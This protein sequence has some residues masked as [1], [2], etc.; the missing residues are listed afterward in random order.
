MNELTKQ[1]DLY[2]Y[3]EVIRQL[4]ANPVLDLGMT[5]KRAG[6]VSRQIADSAISPDTALVGVDFASTPTLQ[7]YTV[8]YDRILTMEKLLSDTEEFP[9]F[10]L[11]VSLFLSELS[12][13]KEKLL[14][15]LKEHCDYILTDF[16]SHDLFFPYF[17]EKKA[18]SIQNGEDTYILLT[19]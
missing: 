14:P 12:S 7:V 5:L 11:G 17:P 3:F 15:F 18:R 19:S 8:L 4:R 13:Y 6:A 2:I 1:N 9:H 10:T 16:G